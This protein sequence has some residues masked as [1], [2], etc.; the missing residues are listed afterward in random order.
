MPIRRR[1]PGQRLRRTR[2]RLEMEQLERVDPD[3]HAELVELRRVSPQAYRKELARLIKKGT[4]VK[5]RT[6]VVHD[7]HLSILDSYD[8]RKIKE[9]VEERI[10]AGT[11]DF[12][13]VGALLQA[14]RGHRARPDLMSYFQQRMDELLEAEGRYVP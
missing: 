8:L 5:G 1:S 6:Y 2:R 13:A 12:R 7:D 9:Q 14:E 11:F 4:I 10:E 3:K